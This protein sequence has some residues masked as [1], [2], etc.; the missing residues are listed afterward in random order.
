M[1]SLYF[2]DL[3]YYKVGIMSKKL[4]TAEELE[5]KTYSYLANNGAGK[6]LLV[7]GYRI[8]KGRPNKNS[9]NYKCRCRSEK[10]DD[11]DI[12]VMKGKSTR[13]SFASNSSF[14]IEQLA[15]YFPRF[16]TMKSGLNKRKL[17]QLKLAAIDVKFQLNPKVRNTKNLIAHKIARSIGSIESSASPSISRSQPLTRT[18]WHLPTSL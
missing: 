18:K 3:L 11:P 5:E 12:E 8:P 7:D 16:L 10:T 14:T 4:A 13:A 17:I 6:D 1:S 2:L 9:Q 15:I